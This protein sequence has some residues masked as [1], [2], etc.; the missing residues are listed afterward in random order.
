MMRPQR[1]FIIF[2]TTRLASRQV[3]VRLV[4]TTASKSSSDMRTRRPS[5]VMPALA[6]ST[7]TGPS[8]SSTWLTAASTWSG[9]VT[10]HFTVSRPG[11]STGVDDEV[12]A[13]RCPAAAKARA[14]PRPMPL[15]PPVIEDRACAAPRDA[16]SCRPFDHGGGPGHA[17][18]EADEEHD[19]ARVQPA[20]VGGVGQRHRDRRRR[21]VARWW[22]GCRRCA[23]RGCRAWR[24]PR[25]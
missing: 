7:S 4:A 21:G 12:T 16:R 8:W 1:A 15:L 20:G 25:R 14:Q 18:A 19:V 11:S 6:T 5:R 22:R 13:T 3:A 24:G 23:P 2:G 17:G 9:S 10:S